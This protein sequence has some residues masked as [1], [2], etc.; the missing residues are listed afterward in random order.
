[1]RTLSR[2]AITARRFWFLVLL[3]LAWAPSGRASAQQAPQQFG[4][5]LKQAMA[6]MAAAQAALE[7][8]L[9]QP[10]IARQAAADEAVR[11]ALAALQAQ[12][13]ALQQA[14]Q[15]IQA[16][17]PAA[18]AASAAPQPDQLAVCRAN[19]AKLLAV[20]H[21]IMHLYESQSFRSLLWHS[22]E[23]VLG[24]WR[25]KLEN[26]VQENDDRLRELEVYPDTKGTR[27]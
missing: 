8:L 25:V 17:A 16:T 23:P 19:N 11:A 2:P 26:I 7:A 14:V 24:L 13:V 21:D 27:P 5:A 4:P 9:R 22:Y 20:G 10:E 18:G 12:T 3:A 6:G 1:M 15:G